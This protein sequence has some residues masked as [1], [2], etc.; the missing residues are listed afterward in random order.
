MQLAD[1]RGISRKM[2][3]K[4]DVTNIYIYKININVYIYKYI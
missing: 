4:H 2:V 3:D 1:E